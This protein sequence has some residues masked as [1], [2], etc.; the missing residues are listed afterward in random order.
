MRIE[1]HPLSAD[2]IIELF[3]FPDG[4]RIYEGKPFSNPHRVL[5]DESGP[6]RWRVPQ[7]IADPTVNIWFVRWIVLP[8]TGEI[9]GSSSFH[10]PPDPSGMVEIGLGIH[11]KFQRQGYG[12]EALVAMWS[13]AVEQP[14]V[15]TLRYTVSPTNL[16]SV[17][18]VESFEF[19]RVGE[20]MDEIDGLEDIYEMSAA[21]FRAR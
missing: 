10:G 6:L 18:L 2:E 9:I 3:E 11:P 8:S 20:Q 21:D 15:G 7:V 5:M 12:R 13:W 17:K 4:L 16:A 1:I 14:K 19:T